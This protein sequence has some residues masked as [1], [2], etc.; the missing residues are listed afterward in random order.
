[1]GGGKPRQSISP[2]APSVVRGH[3]ILGLKHLVGKKC[4]EQ[5][6]LTWSDVTDDEQGRSKG[7][8]TLDR[9]SAGEVASTPR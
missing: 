3:S 5:L 1:M 4:L 8:A 6:N 7:Q 9:L 2:K